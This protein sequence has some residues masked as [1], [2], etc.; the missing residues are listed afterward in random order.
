MHIFVMVNKCTV[1]ELHDLR[2]VVGPLYSLPAQIALNLEGTL[3]SVLRDVTT[4][5]SEKLWINSRK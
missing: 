1:K 2:P 4:V 3:V 5:H